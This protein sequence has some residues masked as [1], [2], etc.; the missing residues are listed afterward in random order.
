MP[1][2]RPRVNSCV[3]LPD[4]EN[5]RLRQ[6]IRAPPRQVGRRNEHLAKPFAL[7]VPGQNPRQT[8]HDALVPHLRRRAHQQLPV[9]QLSPFPVVRECEDLID[10]EVAG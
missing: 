3:L 5:I 1:N 7:T 4:D 6:H 2:V 9:H 8:Q 10:G